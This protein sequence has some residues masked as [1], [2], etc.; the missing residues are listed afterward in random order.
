MKGLSDAAAVVTNEAGGI[1]HSRPYRSEALFFRALLA[2]SH[3]R[4]EAIVER[5]YPDDNYRLI[6]AREHIG[7]ALTH[8]FAW[9]IGDTSNDHLAHA[10]TRV[11]MALEI[12]LEKEDIK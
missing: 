9:M 2:I 6:P 12:E 10:A 7:R 11:L 4:H 1:Q 5:G 3:V 8:L